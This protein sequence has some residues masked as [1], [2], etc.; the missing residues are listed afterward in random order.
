MCALTRVPSVAFPHIA[1]EL[2]PGSTVDKIQSNLIFSTVDTARTVGSIRPYLEARLSKWY[3]E[4]DAGP[5]AE[6]GAGFRDYKNSFGSICVAASRSGAAGFRPSSRAHDAG[7]SPCARNT[8]REAISR[9]TSSSQHAGHAVRRNR[10][11][12]QRTQLAG[13]FSG[14]RQ[15]SRRI[16]HQKCGCRLSPTTSGSRRGARAIDRAA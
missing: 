3:S 6:A 2:S 14:H 11:H 13:T 10:T 4:A 12:A 16:C 9:D 7:L 15:R 5:G 8:I 1:C